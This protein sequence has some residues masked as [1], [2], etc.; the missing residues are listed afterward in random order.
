LAVVM[1]LEAGCT[2]AEVSAIAGHRA[3]WL[4]TT[5]CR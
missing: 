3:R 1:P 4:S 2:D 5:G